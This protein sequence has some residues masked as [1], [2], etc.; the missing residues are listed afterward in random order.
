[1]TLMTVHRA[2]GLEW[3]VVILADFDY[4]PGSA[5]PPVLMDPAL[6][7]ALK[8]E[9]DEG[10][11]VEPVLY[12]ELFALSEDERW[13]PLLKTLETAG[14]RPPDLDACLAPL[15]RA[16]TPAPAQTVLAWDHV[17]LAERGTP[18]E[19]FVTEDDPQGALEALRPY[20]DLGDV[21]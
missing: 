12:A 1:M 19:S 21:P 9:D 2:K 15:T 3:P 16:G 13:L 6:G 11:A 17:A 10:E 7:L 14:I 18:A 5:S 4:S 20:L 8:V